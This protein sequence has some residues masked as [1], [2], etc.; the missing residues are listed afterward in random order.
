MEGTTGSCPPTPQLLLPR[1]WFTRIKIPFG[2]LFKNDNNNGNLVVSI[3]KPP[4]WPKRYRRV[5]LFKRRKK[6]CCCRVNDF[7]MLLY[8]KGRRTLGLLKLCPSFVCILGGPERFPNTLSIFEHRLDW[9]L[10]KFLQARGHT[11]LSA[12][13]IPFK[14]PSGDA[15]SC[16][17][18]RQPHKVSASNVT[19]KERSSNLET[20]R[21][22]MVRTL[23]STRTLKGGPRR[24]KTCQSREGQERVEAGQELDCAGTTGQKVDVA[25]WV[26]IVKMK[27]KTWG[28]DRGMY[29][30][31]RSS[32][33][34]L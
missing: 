11:V 7:F 4:I 6:H 32:V 19:G 13:H 15:I 10:L 25:P 24:G 31:S 27:R 21:Q 2:D 23:C 12:T 8:L 30:Q 22:S 1:P 14:A 16:S 28:R 17:S 9:L 34:P 20:Q 29:P 3:S 5:W 26:I 33:S 18:P